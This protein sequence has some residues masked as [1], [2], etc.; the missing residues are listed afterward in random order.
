MNTSSP[1]TSLRLPSGMQRA[2]LFCGIWTFV[3]FVFLYLPIVLL[4]AYSFNSS[5]LNIRWEGFTLEW[6]ERLRTDTVL[7]TALQN[8]LI[9]ASVS[10]VLAVLLGTTG[11]WLLYRYRFPLTRA[12]STLILRRRRTASAAA[13]AEHEIDLA[14]CLVNSVV[15]SCCLFARLTASFV[16]VW[17]SVIMK[18]AMQARLCYN[19]YPENK[20]RWKDSLLPAWVL[21]LATRDMSLTS[22]PL[23]CRCESFWCTA[24]ARQ[25]EV[26]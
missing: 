18:E 12:L 25:A 7:L 22:R 4:V 23:R 2:H 5:R 8:S 20:T 11:A 6:Y 16:L 13:D 21:E 1:R 26:Q 14:M 9:I 17:N 24:N 3:V 19:I 10:T 15:I